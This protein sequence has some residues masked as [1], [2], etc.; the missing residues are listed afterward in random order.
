[1]PTSHSTNS[2]S[3]DASSTTPGTPTPIDDSSGAITNDPV[4]PQGRDAIATFSNNIINIKPANYMWVKK[5]SNHRLC[6]KGP[7]PTQ[8][9]LWLVGD[10]DSHSL[11][12]A[13]SYGN[14]TV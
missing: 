9:L 14:W 12:S 1:M 11:T 7:E 13:L 3:A 2:A 10:I 8:A 4:Q 6:H 5:F